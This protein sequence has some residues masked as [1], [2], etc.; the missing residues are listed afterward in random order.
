M[1]LT[2]RITRHHSGYKQNPSPSRA[3]PASILATVTKQNKVDNVNESDLGLP[4][5]SDLS[6]TDKKFNI[7]SSVTPPELNWKDLEKQHVKETVPRMHQE[8]Q[9]RQS[10][11]EIAHDYGQERP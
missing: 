9:Q 1:G 4:E 5:D 8:A 11:R 6:Y 2:K 3:H 10:E 7:K